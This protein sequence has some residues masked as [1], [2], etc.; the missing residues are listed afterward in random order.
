MLAQLIENY[1]IGISMAETQL[2]L[3]SGKTE[4]EDDQHFC[5]HLLKVAKSMLDQPLAALRM[6]VAEESV[7]GK[8]MRAHQAEA[9]LLREGL[10]GIFR[11]GRPWNVD[12]I[13]A[14]MMPEQAEDRYLTAAAHVTANTFSRIMTI[15]EGH[16]KER[17]VLFE[18]KHGIDFARRP[19]DEAF[20][21]VADK[22]IEHFKSFL[23]GHMHMGDAIK[24][25]AETGDENAAP[26]RSILYAIMI[27]LSSQTG[28]FNLPGSDDKVDTAVSL[29][30]KHVPGD[31]AAAALAAALCATSLVSR[32]GMKQL[33]N[34]R[35]IFAGVDDE[36]KQGDERDEH[37]KLVIDGIERRRAF[38]KGERGWMRH[39]SRLV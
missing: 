10:I 8:P 20:K 31:F 26:L 39:H 15:N 14:S 5:E 28:L 33:L 7:E 32:P 2:L 34:V 18:V 3:A 37:L 36:N 22:L 13:R 24:R 11:N 9:L 35:S 16:L 17:E 38:W 30:S 29:A 25:I 23:D 27:D 21:A 19:H 12:P 1:F 4:F 6:V